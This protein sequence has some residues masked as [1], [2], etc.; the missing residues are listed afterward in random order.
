MTTSHSSGL[1]NPEPRPCSWYCGSVKA[2]SSSSETH[3]QN[4]QSKERSPPGL[5]SADREVLCFRSSPHRQVQGRLSQ[6]GVGG[7]GLLLD[8]G[9][10]SPPLRSHHLPSLSSLSPSPFPL[11]PTSPLVPFSLPPPLPPVPRPSPFAPASLF[12]VLS[13]CE[14]YPCSVHR[15]SWVVL[16]GWWALH[17]WPHTLPRLCLHVPTYTSPLVTLTSPHYQ[18]TH[19]G[20]W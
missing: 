12:S 17:P 14:G 11:F 19:S 13:Q 8:P 10:G 6:G 3:T 15:D 4:T 5:S 18:D 16:P 1:T 7:H 2:Q 9:S 20:S